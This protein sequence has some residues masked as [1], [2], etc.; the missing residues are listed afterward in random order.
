MTHA[1]VGSKASST[2]IERPTDANDAPVSGCGGSAPADSCGGPWA[3]RSCASMSSCASQLAK[4]APGLSAA[5]EEISINHSEPQ[6]LLPGPVGAPEL[7]PP[8][9]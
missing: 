4:V 9:V 3:T 7:P 8:R 1:T 2:R 5:R 6:T